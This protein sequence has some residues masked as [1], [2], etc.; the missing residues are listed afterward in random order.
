MHANVFSCNSAVSDVVNEGEKALISPFCGKPGE[1]LNALRYQRYFEK[2]PTKTSHIEPQGL[3]PPRAAN[4]TVV[5]LPA[6]KAMPGRR[7]WHAIG[8]V[9][10][11]NH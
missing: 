5:H 4:Y 9:G 1:G 6:G 10:V 7:C 3:S 8:E 2:P 11:E